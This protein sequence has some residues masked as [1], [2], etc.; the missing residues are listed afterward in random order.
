MALP[1]C[2]AVP[3]LL[4]A[5]ALLSCVAY[6]GQLPTVAIA[7][8]VDT[9]NAAPP[10]VTFAGELGKS[11]M[12][13]H[14]ITSMAVD[15]NSG[16]VYIVRAQLERPVCAC[17][18]ARAIRC[19]H[20]ATLQGCSKYFAAFN[21]FSSA[22]I[23]ATPTGTGAFTLATVAGNYAG[24]ASTD[25]VGTSASFM[26]IDSVTVDGCVR[27]CCLLGASCLIWRTGAE[28]FTSM[29]PAPTTSAS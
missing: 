8:Q 10:T 9:I 23:A 14:T 29:T 19:P 20:S 7:G 18:P 28:T 24:S 1:R 21:G 3:C 16:V 12:L 27:L 11:V 25:G 26:R 17:S 2:A 5:A 13:P 22:V 15:P 4:A 6:G